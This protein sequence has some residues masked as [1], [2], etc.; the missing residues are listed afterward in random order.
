[1]RRV[2]FLAATLF[3]AAGVTAAAAPP[4][5]ET[6][7]SPPFTADNVLSDLDRT[8]AWYQQ[9]RATMRSINAGTETVF[10]REDQQT[11]LSTL[12]RAFE[13]AHAEA[14]WLA[15]TNGAS[16]KPGSGT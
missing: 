6:A 10:G 9:T 1:M 12:Q 5:S 16:V 14:A 11:V 4:S 15:R 2:G 8:L 13:A 7:P 3:L